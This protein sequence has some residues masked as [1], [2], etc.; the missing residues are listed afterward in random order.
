MRTPQML[1]ILIKAENILRAGGVLP[2]DLVAALIDCGFDVDAL[3]RK[4]AR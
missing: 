3:E 1:L 4:Y 2:L